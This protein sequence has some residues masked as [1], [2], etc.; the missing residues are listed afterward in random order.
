[1]V[2]FQFWWPFSFSD[3]S[4]LVTFQFWGHFSF[5]DIQFWWHY[6]FGDL[7]SFCDISVLVTFQCWWHFIFGDTSV[8]VTF[9]FWRWDDLIVFKALSNLVSVQRC[10]DQPTNR[11]TTRIKSLS[12]AW[13]GGIEQSGYRHF[14][15]AMVTPN[16]S[17]FRELPWKQASPELAT[18]AFITP[19]K[20]KVIRADLWI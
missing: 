1:M 19:N 11:T 4:V 6:S 17:A 10:N 20:T 9:K 12:M 5:G 8:L 14:C 7:F 3:I 16:V 18:P 2:T 13:L 15:W